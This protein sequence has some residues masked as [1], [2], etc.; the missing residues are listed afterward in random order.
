MS[1]KSISSPLPATFMRD[2]LHHP[3]Y[4]T[5]AVPAADWRYRHDQPLHHPPLARSLSP[6]RTLQSSA[7]GNDLRLGTYE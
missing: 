4:T 1:S 5:G 3:P 6:A 2:A 7:L